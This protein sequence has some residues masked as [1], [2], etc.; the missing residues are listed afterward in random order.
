[1]SET[2]ASGDEPSVFEE[3]HCI[4]RMMLVRAD[5]ESSGSNGGLTIH[6]ENVIFSYVS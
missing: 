3:R 5:G 6:C 2:F 4:V 1:V